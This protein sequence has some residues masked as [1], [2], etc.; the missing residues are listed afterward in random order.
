[1]GEFLEESI[2][3]SSLLKEVDPRLQSFV[4]GVAHALNIYYSP[5]DR[6]KCYLPRVETHK[7]ILFCKQ[8]FKLRSQKLCLT[9]ESVSL[10][11][12][13]KKLNNPDIL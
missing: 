10:L 12:Q 3:S 2:F 4:S 1:M 9:H 8:V 5:C 11:L 7:N 13:R 6:V